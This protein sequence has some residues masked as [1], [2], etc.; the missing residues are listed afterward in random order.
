MNKREF[1]GKLRHGLCGL[2]NNDIEERASFYEE[3][4]DDRME[5]GISEEEAVSEIGSVD[6]I[7]SQIIA[8][9]PLTKLAK[10][11]IKPSKRLKVWEIVL[12]VLGSPIWLSLLIGAFA[13]VLSLYASIWAVIV[14][15]WSVFAS[16]TACGLAFIV[17]GVGI[18]LT[19]DGGI[20]TGLVVI[21]AGI[22]FAGLSI[23]A[24]YLCKA[25]TT[26]VLI[27]TKKLV[28]WIK[29]RFIGKG[30]A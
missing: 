9:T 24:F 11:K 23:F 15:L 8:D 27:I 7:I 3:M 12:L 28:V 2:P 20:V 4:I 5:E 25:L 6:E 30:E 26:G 17:A 1:L 14:S 16:F 18:G 19:P 21:G 29:S 22:L 10:E 13:V